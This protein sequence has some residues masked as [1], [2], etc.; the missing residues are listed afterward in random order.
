MDEKKLFNEK[1]LT[2]LYDACVY[3]GRNDEILN[4]DSGKFLQGLLEKLEALAPGLSRQEPEQE[5]E[6]EL[7]V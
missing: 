2:A 4:Y 7:E 6:N 5:S 3:R 1:E